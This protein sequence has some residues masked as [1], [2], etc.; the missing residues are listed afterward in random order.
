MTLLDDIRGYWDADA[1]TYDHSRQHRP[2]SPMVEAAWTAA[3]EGA[4]PPPPARVLDCGAGTGFL[5]L[6]AASLGHRVTAVDLSG[7]MLERL[8]RRAEETEVEIETVQG[9][10]AAPPAGGYDA[11]VERHL[12]WTLPDP[13]GALAAWRSAAAPHARLVL[14]ESLWGAV[15][16]VERLRGDVRRAIGRVRRQPPEHHAEYDPG[17]RASLPLGSG[18]H[19]SRLVELARG[20]GW[21]TPRLHRL[22]GVEWAERADLPLPERLVGV[23]PRFM[24]VAGGGVTGGRARGKAGGKGG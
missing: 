20:A 22:Y 8:A 1:P 23:T 2:R 4:L 14:V 5:S 9:P 7:A 13:G 10:A 6:I 21:Q 3:V 19:P 24:V 16:P 17:M 18:T 12:L 11:V 15:D